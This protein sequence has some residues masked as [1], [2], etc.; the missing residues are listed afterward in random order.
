MIVIIDG[1]AFYSHLLFK[2]RGTIYNPLSDAAGVI[3]AD[4]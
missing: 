4:K 1:K 2:A 3:C